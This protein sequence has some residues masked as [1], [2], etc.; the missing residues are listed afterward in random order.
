MTKDE[1]LKLA[2]DA[3]KRMK[4]YGDT[5]AYRSSEQNPYEQVCE[6]IADCEQVIDQDALYKMAEE[7]RTSGLRLDDWDKIVCVNHDCAKC[8]AQS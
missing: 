8:K 7:S 2:L 6:A 1:A 4:R 5:F 3:L